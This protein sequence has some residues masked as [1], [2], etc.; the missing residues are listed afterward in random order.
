MQSGMYG[1]V[2]AQQPQPR[3]KADNKSNFSWHVD[4]VCRLFKPALCT[5]VWPALEVNRESSE[6]LVKSVER[7]D[8]SPCCKQANAAAAA[9]SSQTTG[10]AAKLPGHKHSMLTAHM[11]AQQ[12]SASQQQCKTILRSGT[13]QQH[14]ALRA[15]PAQASWSTNPAAPSSWQHSCKLAAATCC[16]ASN[17]AAANQERACC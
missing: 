2:G 10:S 1:A 12:T 17:S 14:L 13:T 15:S 6:I 5:R 7:V 4:S 9:H 16:L 3:L 11:Q 8:G